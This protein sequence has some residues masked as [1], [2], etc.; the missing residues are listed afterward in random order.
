MSPLLPRSAGSIAPFALPLI[1]GLV[2]LLLGVP[3]IWWQSEVFL[4]ERS[5]RNAQAAMLQIER[6]IDS[7]ETTATQARYLAGGNCSEVES[8]LRHEAIDQP[9]VRS[10]NLVQHGRIICTSSLGRY[11]EDE[12]ADRFVDGRLSLMDGNSI[13][14]RR[15]LLMV[16]QVQNGTGVQASIDDF[17]LADA[18]R[19]GEHEPALQLVVGPRWMRADGRV[20]S[21]PLAGHEVAQQ[22]V[23]SAHY[24]FNV[25]AG[26]G[27]GANWRH[28][29]STHLPLLGLLGVLGVAAGVR[30]HR[31]RRA[32]SSPAAELRR[33]LRHDEFVP[34]YQ[35][36]VSASSG[37]WT[38]V[39]VLTRWRHP[40]LGLVPPDHFIPM[41]EGCGLIVPMTRRLMT[42]VRHE[43]AAH[44]EHLPEGFHVGINLTAGHCQDPHLLDDCRQF[45]AAFPP[46]RVQLTLELT[47]RELVQSTP[48]TLQ[49]FADLRALGVR[50]AIDDF[51]TG[52]S[53]LAYL[54]EF[55][56]D[57]LKIDR[58]F[59]SRI[60]TNAV[61]E[62]ILDSIVD[63][64]LR[65]DLGIVA[66]GIETAEQRDYLR[67]RG[68]HCL[69]GYLFGK[70]LP[71]EEHLQRLPGY[72]PADVARLLTGRRRMAH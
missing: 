20:Y 63:L 43:L 9:Y 22:V 46:G 50:L 42:R 57:Y 62:C 39:E 41:A 60:G 68:V 12:G 5:R 28:I 14:P 72:A 1:V 19:G 44:A 54:R 6:V 40:E 11:D 36:L 61:S 69:Q 3:L 21:A 4:E 70:P 65:L 56:V 8:I 30:T 23:A 66:E 13:A 27:P 58:S 49:L 34:Y 33:A 29:R 17:H 37:A 45:L 71:L 7:A 32:R 24:P 53:S 15:P 64:A 2:P 55:Q 38:G 26:Y 18:L 52:Q 10:I 67:R 48:A 31:L 16:R 25:V 35:P 47:E 51:G 59:V